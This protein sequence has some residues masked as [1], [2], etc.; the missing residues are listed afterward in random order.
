MVI[1]RTSKGSEK[2][3]YNAKQLTEFGYTDGE[4]FLTR[5]VYLQD[6]TQA[7][8]FLQMHASGEMDFYSYVDEFLKQ[9]YYI[10]YD[11]YGLRELM[12]FVPE[13]GAGGTK[14][15]APRLLYIGE[16]KLAM[17]DCMK[18][19]PE[20]DQTQLNYKSLMKILEAYY[21]CKG[22]TITKYEKK[23]KQKLGNILDIGVLAGINGVFPGKNGSGLNVDPGS[24]YGVLLDYYIPRTSNRYSVGAA[25]VLSIYDG[26]QGPFRNIDAKVNVKY[27]YTNNKLR[28]YPYGGLIAPLTKIAL[29]F[30]GRAAY[31]G[32]GTD[33]KLGPMKIFLEADMRFFSA[34]IFNLNAGIKF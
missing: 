7:V 18:I 13:M 28:I 8:V 4:K 24:N 23:S 14:I 9:H 31:A 20:I 12:I 32:L 22:A 6:S 26:F 3:F 10:E 30:D 33:I 2:E 19:H 27:Y 21:R 29:A 16:L 1:F 5:S 17:K 15:K 34:R 11:D 25:A